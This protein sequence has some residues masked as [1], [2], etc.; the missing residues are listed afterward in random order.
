MQISKKAE[1]CSLSPIRKFYPYAAA[2]KAAG[3]K[4]YQLNIG[5]P[6]IE[7]PRAFFDALAAV[8]EPVLSYAPSPGMPELIEAIRSY[9]ARLGAD[10][11]PADIAVTTGGSEA[12]LITLLS[13]LDEGDE[14][15]IPEPLYPNY[16]TFVRAAG[17]VIVPLTTRPETGYGYADREK[18]EALI[19][20]KTKAILITNPGN[21]TGTVLSPKEL[22]LLA[23]IAISQDLYLISDEVYREFVYDGQALSTLGAIQRAAENAVIIDSVSKRFSACGA[24]IGAAITK[25]EALQTAILKFQQ[26]RLSTATLDQIG[27]AALY[28]VTPD[29]FD[30]VRAEYKARRDACYQALSKIPGVICTEPQGAFYM[31]AKLPIADTE[32]FLTFLLTEFDDRGETV[33]FA[34][35]A[36]F[37]ATEGMGKDEIRIAYVLQADH[38]ARAMEL[39]GLG[40]AAYNAKRAKTR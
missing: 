35:G 1:A 27:A 21:P 22:E 32:D 6:D 15:I 16:I 19:T 29:Y 18:I 5:Q 9:Y 36:G 25:N 37:Y 13:I 23:D 4:I 2:A 24:R 14:I 38:L 30:A 31:M 7:T 11:A 33:M 8:T 28:D 3:K 26:A 17:G 20:E 40:I 34:P 10:Y 12:L 39:L